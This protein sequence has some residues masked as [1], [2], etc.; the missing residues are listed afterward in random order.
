[1]GR[2]LAEKFPSARRVFDT[3]SKVLGKDLAKLCFD[4]PEADLMDTRNTQ[5]AVMAVGLA[6]WEVAKEQG[7]G[8]EGALGH[9]LGEVT[10][11]VAAGV[12]DMETG[13]RIVKARAQAMVEAAQGRQ[14]T[15]AAVM[16]LAA[17][18]VEEVLK[19]YPPEL[20]LGANWNSD[21]QV[22][23]AGT[24]EGIEKAGADLKKAGAKRVLPLKV[25]GAFHSPGLKPASEKLALF[26]DGLSS[27]GLVKKAEF[28]IY[29]NV[30]G[31]PRVEPADLAEALA[32]QVSSPVRFSDA[33]RAAA[34]AQTRWVE[35][36]GK[37]LAGLVAKILPGSSTISLVDPAGLDALREGAAA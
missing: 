1:M 11:W 3:A 4:G 37:I 8:A 9:S 18:K 31:K 32:R 20:V 17:S 7:L 24:P 29:A 14:G 16:G 25:S 34:M 35:L 2:A 21:D 30:D 6:A 13:F 26:L 10:A 28:P 19:A 22:V 5:P 23:I 27:Q 33:V 12:V 36:G 15:M